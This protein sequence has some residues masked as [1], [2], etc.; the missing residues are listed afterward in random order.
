[1]K[2]RTT[3]QQARRI[4]SL[5]HTAADILY[6]QDMK[7]GMAQDEAWLLRRAYLPG[8]A[9]IVS[10]LLAEHTAPILIPRMA[11]KEYFK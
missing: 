5:A 3:E 10:R 11:A 6:Q 4:E 7:A 9:P 2:Q 1:M 8:L